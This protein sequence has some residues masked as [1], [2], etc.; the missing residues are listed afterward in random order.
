MFL[1]YFEFIKM[2]TMIFMM[3]C[4]QMVMD[5]S[6]WNG[7]FAIVMIVEI[8]VELFLFY[9]LHK[10]HNTY[11]VSCLWNAVIFLTGLW[12]ILTN[13]LHFY[14]FGMCIA[15]ILNVMNFIYFISKTKA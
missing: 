14:A 9:L 5:D 1:K 7:L 2:I 8:I 6:E 15:S 11:K 12:L 10:G 4:L 3:L 13:G